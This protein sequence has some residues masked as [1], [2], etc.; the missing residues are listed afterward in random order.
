MRKILLLLAFILASCSQTFVGED[1]QTYEIH[2]QCA[3]WYTQTTYI[4][5]PDGTTIPIMSTQCG[6]YYTDT[7]L[8]NKK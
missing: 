4:M 1:G 5:N 2:Y 6:E 3:W 8:S 7:T